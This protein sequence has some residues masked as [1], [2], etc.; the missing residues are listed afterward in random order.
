MSYTFNEIEKKI[1]PKTFLKDVHVRFDFDR[2]NVDI[3]KVVK[4]FNTRF[5]LSI[6]ETQM[7]KEL[8]VNSDDELINFD[9]TVEHVEVTLRHPAYKSFDFAL[10]WLP[11]MKDYMQTLNINTVN[12]VYISKYNELGFTLQDN[13][14]GVEV[15][16]GEVFS[17]EL[18]EK[19]NAE[20]K[21]F[22]SMTRWEMFD[23]V[24]GDDEWNSIFSYEYGFSRRAN[25]LTK[26]CLT[27]KT[28]MESND[29]SIELNKLDEVSIKFND[30]LDRGFHW[31]VSKS[32]IE[33][34]EV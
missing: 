15:I 21:D 20:K 26:G 19:M 8:F 22:S 4:F 25:E 16:M 28:I 9:F 24:R 13:S 18:L 11:W 32:I 3:N 12:K 2:A 30:I 27:L 14:I 33:R 29:V 7:F 5:N 1:Y 31:C 34:M 10:K 17:K 23:S 6:D